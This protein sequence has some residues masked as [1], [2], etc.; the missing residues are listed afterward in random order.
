MKK[1]V[2]GSV[3]LAA[4]LATPAMAADMPVKAPGS[5]RYVMTGAASISARMPGGCGAIW[6]GSFNPFV[7]PVSETVR[8]LALHSLELSQWFAGGHG[9]VQYQFGCS[10]GGSFVIGVEGAST[11]TS[12][13]RRG[14]DHGRSS[15]CDSVSAGT[16][17]AF[18][19][20]DEY[21]T[22]GIRVG[23]AWDTWL[24]SV[25]GGFARGVIHTR[26]QAEG[27]IAPA[28]IARVFGQDTH[29]Q[30]GWYVG[31]AVEKMVAKGPFVD[32]IFGFEYQ[33][34]RFDGERHCEVTTAAHCPSVALVPA[35]LGLGNQLSS[36]GCELGCAYRS[37][38]A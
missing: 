36:K 9:G 14:K 34:L 17:H 33:Y 30:D 19:N 5:S 4:M 11:A 2:L 24:F 3:A 10:P 22:I 23:W 26:F 37:A 20:L 25:N 16:T 29:T 12:R 15:S 13:K 38:R 7:N 8:R 35:P 1:F 18:A 21:H 31:A 6:S 27:T 28:N 32:A